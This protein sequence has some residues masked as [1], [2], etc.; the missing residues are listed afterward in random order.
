MYRNLSLIYLV[1]SV[2]ALAQTTSPPPVLPSPQAAPAQKANP[3]DKVVCR[4]E[5]TIGSR[6]KKHKVCATVRE[7]QEQEAENRAATQA[8]QG[9]GTGCPEGGGGPGC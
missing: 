9:V 3:L 5:E 2:P 1:L 4:Y 8:M 7:W 6:L